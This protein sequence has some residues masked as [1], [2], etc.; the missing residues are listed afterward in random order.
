MPKTIT[1]RLNSEEELMM[2]KL[3]KMYSC[4]IST[5]LKRLALEKLEDE[6]DIE[7]I[8]E[9]EK[10]SKNKDVKFINQKDFEEKFGL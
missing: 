4:G 8:K 3:S 5:A 1:I 10:Q 7:T 6:Y 2:E 9:F